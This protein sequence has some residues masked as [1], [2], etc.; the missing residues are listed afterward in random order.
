[1]QSNQEILVESILNQY[2][3]DQALL[4]DG[5]LE[6]IYSI[7]TDLVSSSDVMSYTKQ[8]GELLDKKEKTIELLEVLDE[9]VHIIIHKL[10]FITANDRPKVIVLDGLNP[11]IINTSSYLQECIKIAGG[12]P[13]NEI[14]EAD[15]IIIINEEEITIAQVPSLL[16]ESVW[17]ESNAIKL[18]QVFLI[19]KAGFGNTPG[20][21][22][23]LELETLAEIL[24]PKYFFYG[25]EGDTWMQF[26]LA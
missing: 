3:V 6:T 12:I 19:N 11:A 22:Y 10:K 7:P 26:Q 20:K 13:T 16:S 5:I 4:P 8:V 2:E 14:L 1:M 24:Q 21:N 17:N 25:L 23:C 15:K 9:E 18:N